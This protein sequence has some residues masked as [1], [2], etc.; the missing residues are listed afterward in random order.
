MKVSNL[1]EILRSVDQDAEVMMPSGLVALQPLD[2]KK[3][4]TALSTPSKNVVGIGESETQ[5]S[6]PTKLFVLG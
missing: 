6:E 3:F 5:W 1:I 4:R 2:E